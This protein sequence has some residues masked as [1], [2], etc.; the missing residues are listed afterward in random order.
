MD[1]QHSECTHEVDHRDSVVIEDAVIEYQNSTFLMNTK[2]MQKGE[3]CVCA[4]KKHC[5]KPSLNT[6]RNKYRHACTVGK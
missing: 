2:S 1:C 6:R 3:S 5:K 4:R